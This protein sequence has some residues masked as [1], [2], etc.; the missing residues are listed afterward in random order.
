MGTWRFW[1][2]NEII[3]YVEIVIYYITTW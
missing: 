2:S 3:Y 1:T